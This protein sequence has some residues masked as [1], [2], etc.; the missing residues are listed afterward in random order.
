MFQLGKVK[1]LD[2]VRGIALLVVLLCHTNPQVFPG[3]NIGVDLFFVLSGFLITSILLE[4]IEK[5]GTIDFYRFYFRR[6]C[7]LLPALAGAVIFV[8]IHAALTERGHVLLTTLLDSLGVSFYYFNWVLV[9]SGGN[10]SAHQQMYTHL[11]SLS[12]E[13]Q[14]Y[15]LWPAVLLMAATFRYPRAAF[16]S[17][18][19]AIISWP[20]IGRMLIWESGP[21]LDL[22]FRTDLRVDSLMFGALA[23]WLLHQGYWPKDAK[24]SHRLSI[25]GLVSLALFF[26]MARFNLLSNGFLYL[27]GYTLV[28]VS[29]A[30]YISVAVCDPHPWMKGILEADWLRWIGRV[31]YGLYIWHVPMFKLALAH[32]AQPWLQNFLAISGT[33]AVASLSYRYLETPFL[34]MKNGDGYERFKAVIRRDPVTT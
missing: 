2:G 27:G 3:G 13:E 1:A 16:L 28:G 21:S 7:R 4:E 11:W 18:I 6:A 10:A 19:A 20:T 22:Y 32:I 12:I 5:T 9:Y 30:L 8:L 29:C 15:I 17:A 34:R 23:S 24:T 14:F 31:S 26:V 25:A 33:F